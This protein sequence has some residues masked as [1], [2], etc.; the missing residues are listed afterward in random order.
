MEF[1]IITNPFVL[2]FEVGSNGNA[3]SGHFAL[4]YS[5]TPQNSTAPEVAG[6]WLSLDAPGYMPAGSVGAG[7][8][9]DSG[10]PVYVGC[11]MFSQPSVSATGSSVMFT[12]PFSICAGVGT[13]PTVSNPGAA[14]YSTGAI[15]GALQQQACNTP[16]CTSEAYTLSQLC[17]MVD[18]IPLTNCST[19]VSVG[20]VVTTGRA[21]LDY[22]T[23]PPN[24]P[25]T[26]G[27]CVPVNYVGLSGSQL[28]TIVLPDNL[29]AI[30]L[31]GVPACLYWNN[32]GPAPAA[33]SS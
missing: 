12:L 17:V 4:C 20:G 10:T 15:V 26:L 27:I 7:C 23:A 33:C 29:G 32:A 5:T 19:S 31:V 11:S 2:A 6:G 8:A 16:G 1:P 24:S 28:A 21:P 30:P 22:S 13:C 18:G 3:A 14:P 25:C 9:P